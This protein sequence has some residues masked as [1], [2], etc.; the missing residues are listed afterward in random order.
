MPD[1]L[2]NPYQ[3]PGAP[4]AAPGPRPQVLKNPRAL[5]LWACY[6]HAAT[7]ATNI[8]VYLAETFI[9]YDTINDVE[10]PAFLGYAGIALAGVAT[11]LASAILFLCWKYRAA[12]NAHILDPMA[13]SVTPGLAVGG[14]FIP[15][16]N[17]YIPYKAMAGISRASIGASWLPGLWWTLYLVSTGCAVALLGEESGSDEIMPP[18]DIGH[19]WLVADVLCATVSIYLVMKITSAQSRRFRQETSAANAPY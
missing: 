7:T 12:V 9:S 5:A 11:F 15:F 2:A 19:I 4:A 1:T 17:L 14:Y 8:A 10:S 16:A 3:T 13:M 6:L 18:G